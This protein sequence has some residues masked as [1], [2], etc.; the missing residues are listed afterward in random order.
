MGLLSPAS[1][2]QHMS[3]IPMT[4][5]ARAFG[6]SDHRCHLL[7]QLAAFTSVSSLLCAVRA[8]AC[9]VC[10]EGSERPLLQRSV[11]CAIHTVDCSTARRGRVYAIDERSLHAYS[12]AVVRQ[13]LWSRQRIDHLVDPDVRLS[14]AAQPHAP[15]ASYRVVNRLLLFCLPSARRAAAHALCC[16]PKGTAGRVL[17]VLQ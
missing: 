17:V 11:E 16:V 4:T 5:T 9:R 1:A 14:P 13:R 7:L 15:V 6:H 3:I 12:A 8:R 10:M 2:R